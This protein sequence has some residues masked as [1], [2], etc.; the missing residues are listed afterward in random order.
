[1]VSSE[2]TTCSTEKK[3]KSTRKRLNGAGRKPKDPEMEEEL[4]QWILELRSRH[5]RVSRR[6]IRLQARSLSPDDEFK[7]SR[8]WLYRFMKR[9]DLSLRRKTTVSQSVPSDVIPKLV[10]FILHLRSLKTKHVYPTDSIYA[11]D[12]TAC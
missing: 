3:K 4:F 6:M 12:E 5:L 10:S 8:G 2:R 1:M 7:A 11:M 9:H